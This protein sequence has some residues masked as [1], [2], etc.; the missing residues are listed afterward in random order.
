[1][2]NGQKLDPYRNIVVISDTHAGCQLSLCPDEVKLDGGGEYKANRL[3]IMLRSYWDEFWG[4]VVPNWVCGQP[5]VVVHNGDAVDGTPHG[6]ISQISGNR[7]TQSEIA[8]QMLRPV[9]Q[10][11]EGRY[12]HIRGTES[13]VGKSA[14]SEEG[15]ASSLGAVPDSN[16]N[17]A[18]YE[19]W[20]RCGDEPGGLVHFNHHV[21][22]CSRQAYE[23]S[24]VMAELTEAFAEAARW[25]QE[26]P[27]CVVRS[28]RHRNIEIRI[29]TRH[30]TSLAV[31]TPAWQCKTPF[32]F[33]V[34][35]A[36]QS[37]PQIGG[38]IIQRAGSDGCY[39][40]SKVWPIERSP[41]AN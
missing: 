41:V 24:A 17:R 38:I 30:G 3:Q 14:E 16:G 1:M 36:R 37:Q 26:P 32:A 7:A 28:H 35:G 20:L 21:G 5:F 39:V 4:E 34:A 23:S 9:F 29:P 15:V 11:C 33:K 8:L 12:Y 19:L 31:V 2:P 18:R 22:T 40:R 25:G 13:H 6:S 10:Q 27:S